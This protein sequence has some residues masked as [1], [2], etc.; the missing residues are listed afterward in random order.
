MLARNLSTAPS[1]R[2]IEG[3]TFNDAT[4]TWVLGCGYASNIEVSMSKDCLKKR[5]GSECYRSCDK[6]IFKIDRRIGSTLDSRACLRFGAE[7]AI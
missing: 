3:I 7:G 4:L 6:C 1:L 5:V 2:D